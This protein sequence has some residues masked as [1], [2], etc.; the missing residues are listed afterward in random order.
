VKAHSLFAHFS[1]F[2]KGMPERKGSR[3]EIL[4]EAGRILPQ[5][6]PLSIFRTLVNWGR[7]TELFGY[8]RDDD[9]FYLD[10]EG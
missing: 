9:A 1:D 10:S 5:E 8:N 4:V 2:L 6:K 7:Y 3:E